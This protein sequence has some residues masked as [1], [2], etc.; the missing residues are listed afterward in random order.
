METRQEQRSYQLQLPPKTYFVFALACSESYEKDIVCQDE[1][2]EKRAYYTD[3]VICGFTAECG[4]ITTGT[5]IPVKVEPGANILK[6]DPQNW[7][8]K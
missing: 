8:S 3:H 1:Y 5:P 2:L 6:I 7:Y 4:Q